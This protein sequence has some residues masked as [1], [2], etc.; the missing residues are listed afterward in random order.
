MQVVTSEPSNVE[1]TNV[2]MYVESVILTV[3]C[4]FLHIIQL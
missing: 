2:R 3:Y 1:Y 4:L